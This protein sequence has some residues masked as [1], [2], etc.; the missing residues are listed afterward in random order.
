MDGGKRGRREDLPYRPCV[1]IMLIDGRGRV[2]VGQRV[3]RDDEAWQ[4][5]QGGIDKG[6]SPREAALRELQEEVGL[7]P[8]QVEILAETGNWY[9]YDLPARL[10]PKVWGGKYRGQSQKWF[11]IRY[12]GSDE[13]ID[14]DYHHRE[15]SDWQW[16]TPERL[17][18]LIVTFKRPLYERLLQE[19]AD[20]LGV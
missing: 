20:R 12:E 17:P 7:H 10:I 18:E 15:F 14:L 9:R 5:P 19:F 11:L 16:V 6:E 2:F 4:M 3:D 1:G 8:E 13:A